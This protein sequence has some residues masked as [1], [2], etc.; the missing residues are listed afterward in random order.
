MG[1]DQ[2]LPLLKWS[3]HVD[4]LSG[5]GRK[6]VRSQLPGV[7][8][9]DK[10][11]RAFEEHVRTRG[12]S[13]LEATYEAKP[14]EDGGIL[15]IISYDWTEHLGPG[16]VEREY[17]QHHVDYD[18]DEVRWSSHGSDETLAESSKQYTSTLKLYREPLRLEYSVALAATRS[19][20][21][22]QLLLVRLF[23]QMLGSSAYASMEVDSPSG[24]GK[25]VLTAPIQ[26]SGVLPDAFVSTALER[27]VTDLGGRRLRDGTV[28]YTTSGLVW[29]TE[30]KCHRADPAG[31]LLVNTDFG[32]DESYTEPLWE[33]YVKVHR[34]PF[35]LEVWTETREGVQSGEVEKHLIDAI[36]REVVSKIAQ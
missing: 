9:P 36:L 22:L 16:V 11:L 34:S 18:K 12:P 3:T 19:A 13:K 14:M 21:P 2:S 20:G 4:S 32:P 7:V 8:N 35:R 26:D 24:A 27:A 17:V 33:T 10:L 23:L 30:Y 1:S 5:D 28:R 31:D 29:P 25:S 15:A 6:V